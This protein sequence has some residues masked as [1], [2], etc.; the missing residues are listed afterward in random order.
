MAGLTK[1]LR[2]FVSEEEAA[3]SVE[4]AVMLMLIA[5]V[6]ISVIQGLGGSVT[7]LWNDNVSQF[8]NA[9]QPGP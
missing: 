5:G 9:V 4:Y 8:S 3:T 6:C 1:R 2:K 7:F